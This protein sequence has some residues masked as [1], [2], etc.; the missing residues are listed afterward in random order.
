[1]G[2]VMARR[3]EI[4]QRRLERREDA[5]WSRNLRIQ[6]SNISAQYKDLDAADELRRKGAATVENIRDRARTD[7]ERAAVTSVKPFADE[8][9]RLL[10]APRV[11]FTGATRADPNPLIVWH[12]KVVMPPTLRDRIGFTRADAGP[13][14][15]LRPGGGLGSSDS[16]PD[17]LAAAEPSL[18]GD[19]D[20][21]S[22]AQTV[23]DEWD[24]FAR[25]YGSLLAKLRD[26]DWWASLCLAAG[27]AQCRTAPETLNGR[28]GTYERKV[29]LN[30]IPTFA[31]VDIGGTGLVLKIAHQTGDSGK[32]WVSKV[33]PVRAALK[34]SG[35]PASGLTI[36]ENSTGD[37]ILNFNDR[38][39]FAGM[40]PESG[41]FDTDRMRSLLGVTA[42]GEEAWVTWSGSSGMVIGGVP[43]SGKTA[44][45]LPIFGGMAGKA[46]L[47]VFD[48]KSG[49]DLHPLRHI[50]QTY[51]RSGDIGAPLDT[52]RK[53][54]T[55]RAQRAEGMYKTLGA[56]NFWNIPSRD[57]DRF[58]LTPVFVILD[59]CQTWLD[60]SGMDKDEKT[61][62]DEIRKLVRTLIQK[63]R[64][65]GIVVVLTTQKPDSVSVPTVIRDNASLKVCFRVSTPEQAV[66]VLGRQAPGAP[67]PTEI[68]MD[69]KG[70]GVMET[71]G[72]G[73]VLFQA[74]YVSADELEQTLQR[75]PTAP[76]PFDVVDGLLGTDGNR[77]PTS[78]PGLPTTDPQPKPTRRSAKPRQVK[79]TP[80]TGDVPQTLD[81]SALTPE[82]RATL[83]RELLA[84]P[85]SETEAETPTPT[86]PTPNVKGVEL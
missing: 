68:R 21:M 26:D 33:D 27:V 57:R 67:D 37:V 73:I 53:L 65:A 24:D 42:S 10:T 13:I 12:W 58:Q 77:A 2:R 86:T 7:A 75:A 9:K 56:N 18:S 5:L 30:V 39:P 50:A 79:P 14:A 44:S 71:E 17:L 52:L 41:H 4:A 61:V 25:N 20:F 28:F 66:T 23:A 43:G 8:E 54:E 62:S 19:P 48:G 34:A 35:A 74:G 3:N 31:G 49:F 69:T 46:S 16:M 60:Q 82:Q 38:D 55:L 63:G 76:D 1:M 85:V 59:E 40:I 36:N 47:F 81:L 22:W 70:R 78:S 84:A 83:L 6:D 64:S 45:F 15:G 29:T 80:T 32:T 51:D 11:A 72:R